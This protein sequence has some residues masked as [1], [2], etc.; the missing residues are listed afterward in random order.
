MRSNIITNIGF[1]ICAFS[2]I[3]G[4]LGNKEVA[5]HIFAFG[6][7]LAVFGFAILSFVSNEISAGQKIAMGGFVFAALAFIPLKYFG[8]EDI[9]T[10]MLYL[11]G[12]VILLGIVSHA[13]SIK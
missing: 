4:I 13:R 11:G 10:A 5:I 9:S 3:L 7:Y 6:F 1:T 8:S 12:A 2:F